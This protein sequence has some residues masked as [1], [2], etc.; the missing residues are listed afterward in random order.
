VGVGRLTH[1]DLMVAMKKYLFG[2]EVATFLAQ[3]ISCSELTSQEPRKVA[4]GPGIMVF[5]IKP[6]HLERLYP[7]S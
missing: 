6:D 3:K 2:V 7:S 5:V 1:I 4:Q